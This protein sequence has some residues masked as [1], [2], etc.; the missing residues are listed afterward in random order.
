MEKKK[1][2]IKNKLAHT[3]RYFEGILYLLKSILTDRQFLY[4]S[5]VIVGISSALAVI[6]LKT[7]AHSVHKF[8][9]YIDTRI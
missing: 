7:F 9:T 2:T 5:C 1:N 3:F 8:A 4:L 6:V